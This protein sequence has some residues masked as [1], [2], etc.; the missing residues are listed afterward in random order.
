MCLSSEN[1][2]KYGTFSQEIL[3][4]NYVPLLLP[5][6]FY[7]FDTFWNLV[8]YLNN[9]LL[10][11]VMNTWKHLCFYIFWGGWRETTYFETSYPKC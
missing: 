7:D 8:T 2:G 6:W 5:A 3:L 10:V 1:K 9:I 4:K 11:Y